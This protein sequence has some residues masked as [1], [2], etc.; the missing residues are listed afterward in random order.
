MWVSSL[1]TPGTS[2]EEWETK[3]VP[4]WPDPNANRRKDFGR[5]WVEL[6]SERECRDYLFRNLR[7]SLMENVEETREIYHYQY[8]MWPDHGVPSDPGGVLNFLQEVNGVQEKIPNAGPIIV[9]CSAGI[10]RTGTI[11][12]ID[13]LVD[14]I[15]TKGVDSDI[16]VQKTI[17]MVRDQRSGMVQTEAQYKFIYLAIAHFI[18]FEK[19]RLKVLENS[20]QTEPEYGNLSVSMTKMKVTQSSSKKEQEETLYE[21]LNKRKEK[22]ETVKKKISEEKK[23]R[24]SLKKK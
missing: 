12:V 9:H 10:G 8:T 24:S 2:S 18:D 3:C 11:I 14:V 7:L 6:S 21:N 4:Y 16:D 17:Q 13:M 1:L 23:S 20:K 5:F 22:K 15:Q 19:Q